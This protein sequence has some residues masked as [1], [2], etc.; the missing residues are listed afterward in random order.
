MW[1]G[2]TWRVGLSQQLLVDQTA[3][4][5]PTRPRHRHAVALC[6]LTRVWQREALVKKKKTMTKTHPETW[7]VVVGRQ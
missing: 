7:A 2:L 5:W 3:E 1:G 6:A 4:D